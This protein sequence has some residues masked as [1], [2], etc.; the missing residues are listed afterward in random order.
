MTDAILEFIADTPVSSGV[1]YIDALVMLLILLPLASLTDF[2]LI[3]KIS[4]LGTSVIFLIFILIACYGIHEN[5]FTGFTTAS[6]SEQSLWPDGFSGFSSW[7]VSFLCMI[8]CL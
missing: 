5:G 3:A 2:T 7:Y 6:L 1:K 4:A 8:F